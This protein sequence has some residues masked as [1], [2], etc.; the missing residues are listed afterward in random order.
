MGSPIPETKIA[1]NRFVSSA[2]AAVV[3]A[4]VDDDLGRSYNSPFCSRL[5]VLKTVTKVGKLV[6]RPLLFR[7]LSVLKCAYAR[8]IDS[9]PDERMKKQSTRRWAVTGRD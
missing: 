5:L 3:V 6:Q 9:L 2:P 1:H 4:T 8:K 7:V